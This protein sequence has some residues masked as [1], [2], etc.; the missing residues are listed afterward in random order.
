MGILIG[1]HVVVEALKAGHPPE[2]VFIAKGAA[3]PR[4]QEI[5]DLCR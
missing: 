2:R 3:G 5:I 1:V 4:L